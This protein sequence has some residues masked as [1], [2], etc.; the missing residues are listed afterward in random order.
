MNNKN[1]FILLILFIGF[2]AY[3]VQKWNTIKDSLIEG[4]FDSL[5]DGC[6]GPD[7]GNIFFSDLE[8]DKVTFDWNDSINSKWEIQVQMVGNTTPVASGNVVTQKPITITNSVGLGAGPLQP[9]TEYEFWIRSICAGSTTKEWIG[10]IRFKTLCD[11]QALPFWEGF[12]STSGTLGC[13]RVLDKNT[14]SM[15]PSTT[16]KIWRIN[17]TF[18]PIPFE[19][20]QFLIFI[21]SAIAAP[22]NDFL[23]SPSFLLDD[24]KYYRLKY[25]YTTSVAFKSSFDVVLSDKGTKP[26]SFTKVLLSKKDHINKGVYGS[27]WSD[28][29]IIIGNTKGVVNIGWHI[30]STASA[31][32]LGID[33]VFLE[34]IACPEPTQLDVKDVEGD[35]ATL[36]WGDDFGNKW[37]YA[38]QK[39]GGIAPNSGIATTQKEASITQENN[40]QALQSNTEYEFYVRTNCDQG[41]YGAWSGPFVFRTACAVLKTP[42]WEGFNPDS[43]TFSCWSIIDGN[44]DSVSPVG[45]NIWKSHSIA[46]EG[47]SGM[48]FNGSARVGS[49]HND[50]LITPTITFEKNKVYRL[51]YHYKTAAVASYDYEFEVLLSKTG[52]DISAFSQVVVPKAKYK[53]GNDWIEKIVLI[54]E[55]EG[56]VN[57]AWHITSSTATQI[58]IDN[59]FIEEVLTCPEPILLETKDLKKD[60]A[61]IMWDNDFGASEWEYYVQREGLGTPIAPGVV[62]NKK[63]NTVSKEISG[64]QLEPNTDYEFYV[65]TTCNTGKHSIWQGPFKFT[66]SC[67]VYNI[68]FTEDFE[69]TDKTYRCWTI[70]DE[71]ADS[72]TPTGNYIWRLF[73]SSSGIKSGEQ[74]MYFFGASGKKNNDWLISPTLKMGTGKYVLKFLYKTSNV[75]SY[76]SSFEVLLSSNGTN[77][78]DFKTT[79]LAS[80]VYKEANWKE[81]VVFFDGV[82]GDINLAWH[83]EAM[84]AAA[85]YIDHI[86]LR[87]VENCPEPYYVT[88]TS[89]TSNSI[90]IDWEQTGGVTE[91]EVIVVNY[92]DNETATPIK[93][94]VVTGDSKTTITGLDEGTPYT[95]YVRAKC[96]DN[97]TKSDWSSPLQITTKVNQNDDCIGA[98]T[99]PVNNTL[100]CIKTISATLHGATNTLSPKSNCNS[101]NAGKSDVW[102]EFTATST[103]HK[104]EVLNLMSVSGSSAPS[105]YA[106]IYNQPCTSMSAPLE[107]FG[108]FSQTTT[109]YWILQN[110]T[111]GT[112]YYIRLGT[113]V[114]SPDFVFNLCITT[115]SDNLALIV[116]PSNDNGEY[117]EE[118]LVK[119]ILVNSTCNLVSN[120]QYKNGDG[121]SNTQHINTLGYF[122]RG[123]STFPFEEGIVLSTNEVEFVPGPF[124][125]QFA[126]RGNNTYRWGGDKDLID[127]INTAGGHPMAYATNPDMRVT[128][129][130]FDFIPLKDS[131]QFDYLFASNSYAS[132][133][134]YS[135][136][137][138]ALFAAWLVD[139]KTGRAQNLANIENTDISIS[140]NTIRDSEKSGIPCSSKNEE[141][142]WKHYDN[143]VDNPLES[144]IDFIGFTKAMKSKKVVIV[145]GRKYHIKLAVMDFC[146]VVSHS[147]A[148]FF[149]KGSFDMDQ[150]NLGPDLLIDTNNALCEGNDVLIESGIKQSEE[151]DTEIAWYKNNVLITDSNKENLRVNEPGKYKVVLKF[152]ELDC[153]I[154][155]EIEVEMYPAISSYIHSADPIEVC[156]KSLQSMNIDLTQ[157]EAMMFKDVTRGDF[158]R[159]YFENESD[160]MAF[161]NKIENPT[162]YPLGT[163][164][165]SKN[166]VL[167]VEN[168]KTGCFEFFTLPISVVS[169]VIPTKI[170]DLK[171]CSEYVFPILS[172]NQYYY[173]ES[174]G[175]GIAY[176]ANDILSTPGE[177]TIYIL[178]RNGTEGCFEETSYRVTITAAVKADVFEDIIEDCAVYYLKEL[179]PLNNYYRIE[180]GAKIPL[181]AGT[182]ILFDTTIYIYT[183]SEDGLCNDESSFNIKYVDCP[184]QKGIS[185]NGDGLNDYLDLSSHGVTNLKIYNRYGTEVY[186]YGIGYT[187]EWI[188]QD[189]AGNQLPDGTYYYVAISH[190]KSRSGWI[191]INR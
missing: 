48:W 82:P 118:E 43:K 86:T 156:R 62:T 57:I 35:S 72:T 126:A 80:K 3:G 140:V 152:N 31:V 147:S 150:L 73:T 38:V 85:V 164:H 22:F 69:E 95:I 96:S 159:T 9:D 139:T 157:V 75:A 175:G 67:T 121:A 59:V 33:N 172:E 30:K 113:S 5:E 65:R 137:N 92:G 183:E 94:L 77:P 187:K 154:S 102:F 190:H 181:Q 142:Y 138:A 182:P 50:W 101:G 104:F 54:K 21:G 1:Y 130:E 8:K 168:N 4:S 46:Y 136:T 56:N 88:L 26:S 100:E 63:E 89:G 20:N 44:D 27:T 186:S 158:S 134:S 45:N 2:G 124:R 40:G 70:I 170:A 106:E 114:S 52:T 131:I 61:T 145:P 165:E 32:S 129:L 99:I 123:K 174:K 87:K 24:T 15:I 180:N 143:G 78:V 179:S 111:A 7:L 58:S 189:N 29:K 173:T 122:N 64:K 42:F 133:C 155:G 16:S 115:A 41:L 167:R 71:N 184:I 162:I 76:N 13:W 112:K 25:N 109:N 37:E 169:G 36:V 103:T 185:P 91:W 171:V 11:T 12:N 151:L 49:S 60:A 51:K 161:E 148:V 74:C 146:P 10:P 83:A 23:I 153:E 39:S 14:T 55:T 119:S 110:L 34:E 144:P 176:K 47:I 116:S 160:A 93:Q 128:Q 66:T 188:G 132:K 107:C 6:N 84:G 117:N 90:N 28:E 53:F 149:K 97:Q 178:Q 17:S 127:I 163:I 191:Q 105:L 166:L 68:P 177:H 98:I 141:Y 125:G 18:D 120:V 79:I 108:S 135:C 81:A 19:G